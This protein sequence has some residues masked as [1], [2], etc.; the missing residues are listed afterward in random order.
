LTAGTLQLGGSSNGGLAS[1]TLTFGNATA[2]AA[3]IQAVTSDRIISNQLTLNQNNGTF[4]GSQS[5]QVNG[6]FLNSGGNRT[7]TSSLESGRTLTLA[8]QVKLSE[9]ATTGRTLTITGTGETRVSGQV[10]NGAT[11]AGGLTKSGTGLLILAN[12][13]NLYTGATMVNAGTLLVNGTTAAESAVTVA[14][15]AT[16]GGSGTINGPVTVNAG[17]HL[18]PGASAGTLSIGGSLDLSAQAAGGTGRLNFELD[19]LAGLSDKI[20]VTGT[21]TIGSGLLGFNDFVFTNLGGLQAGTYKLITSGGISGTLDGADLSSAIGAFTGTLQ[22]TGND[23]ELV[24]TGGGP[25]TPLAFSGVGP[26]SGSSFSLTFNGP[27]GQNYQVLTTTNIALPMT[28][29]TLLTTGTF[30]GSPV[31]YTNTN[32]TNAQ[33]FYRLV[34]TPVIPPTPPLSE[35]FESGATG[36]TTGSD[37]DTGTAWEL[38]VPENV[39]PAAAHSPGNCF[40]TNIRGLYG[41]NANVWLR[42]PVID[43]TTAPSATLRFWQFKNIEPGMDSGSVRLLDASDNSELVVVVAVVDG[44]TANWEQVSCA[45]PPAALGR[46]I[47]LEFRFRSDGDLT[48]AGWYIDDVAVT[49]P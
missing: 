2:G 18:A 19:A 8:G 17:G 10:V 4:S 15:N 25:L 41:V 13:N 32:A 11:G 47:K 6:I 23:L 42:S 31:I 35:N 9:H 44:T 33:Q 22:I 29:W 46:P 12:T 34:L 5:P 27:S 7:L 3:V 49:V 37:G 48:F 45:L 36:W 28:N 30:S 24:V 21:L 26:L 39:G 20:A 16:L 43:L 1:G 38:G 40:G 14:T